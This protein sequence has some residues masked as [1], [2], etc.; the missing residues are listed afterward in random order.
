LLRFL[1]RPWLLRRHRLGCRSQL[2]HWL[3]R[4]LLR[5]RWLRGRFR[6]RRR[7]RATATA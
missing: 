3:W 7:R 4:R 5:R 2:R 6:L 1:Q